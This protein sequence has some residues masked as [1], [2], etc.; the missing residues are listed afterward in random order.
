MKGLSVGGLPG[1]LGGR[2]ERETGKS[3]GKDQ[4]NGQQS[5]FNLQQG[6]CSPGKTT[7]RHSAG[8]TPR[9]L[10]ES[11]WGDSDVVRISSVR[12]EWSCLKA[13][14]NDEGPGCRA[15]NKGT[16][17]RWV[18]LDLKDV[19]DQG[20]HAL[21]NTTRTP[22]WRLNRGREKKTIINSNASPLGKNQ[23]NNLG[24]MGDGKTYPQGIFSTEGS[25]IT[26]QWGVGSARKV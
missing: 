18:V 7:V 23:V 9:K 13:G 19:K 2:M 20:C 24:G 10:R 11:R 22:E 25:G 21:W 4:K 6:A 26:G 5:G 12:G 14:Q 15:K 1:E 16:C 3:G 17:P 8:N